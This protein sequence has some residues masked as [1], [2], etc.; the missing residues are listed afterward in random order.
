M[1]FEESGSKCKE[2]D[3]FRGKTPLSRFI[4]RNFRGA[5]ITITLVN[6]HTVEGEVVDGFDGLIGLKHENE[7]RFINERFIT[8]FI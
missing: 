4:E 3:E 7:I 2:E 6:G 5:H 8:S 1:G